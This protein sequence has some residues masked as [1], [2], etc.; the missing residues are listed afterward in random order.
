MRRFTPHL[1]SWFSIGAFNVPRRSR[2]SVDQKRLLPPGIRFGSSPRR[3]RM[4]CTRPQ[5]A[6]YDDFKVHETVTDP[7]CS[8]DHSQEIKPNSL[9]SVFASIGKWALE[10][11]DLLAAMK[12][13][14]VDSIADV[15][16]EYAEL[17]DADGIQTLMQYG[18]FPDFDMAPVQLSMLAKAFK[19]S[20]DQARFA[21]LELCKRFRER[22]SVIESNLTRALPH[23]S[24]IIRE[25]FQAHRSGQW[26]LSVIAI[27]T[28]VDGLFYD[29]WS[30]NLFRGIDR[31][32]IEEVIEQIP[33]ELGR[34]LSRAL[35][36]DGWPLTLS[37]K[38]RRHLSP[39]TAHLNRHQVLH[40]E[41]TNFGSEENSLKVVS[42]LNYCAFA[43]RS[44]D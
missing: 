28:Q 26:N 5:L 21:D 27:L 34:T 8:T 35:L 4:V 29:A 16:S 7:K 12:T 18:W 24:V 32:K 37:S 14:Y 19:H 44:T 1:Q 42:L 10:N 39:D 13:Y 2:S 17:V 9:V 38:K 3:R 6:S 20:P 25:A 36:Y 43:L 11:R 22:L 41:V 40:G 23:R 30:I 15:E 33:D 31:S